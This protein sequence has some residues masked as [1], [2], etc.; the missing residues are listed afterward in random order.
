V[1]RRHTRQVR[2]AEV[3]ADGQGRIARATADVHG[4]GLAAQVA[5]RYLAGAGLAQLRVADEGVAA[6]ARGIDASVKVYVD[7]SLAVDRAAAPSELVDP[8][9]CALAAGALAALRAIREALSAASSHDSRPSPG[10]RADSNTGRE[11]ET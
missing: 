2:L 10:G 5:A 8:T 6:A 4:R 11:S 3:G 7:T 9:A 1:S